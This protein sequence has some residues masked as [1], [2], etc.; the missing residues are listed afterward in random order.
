MIYVVVMK[1]GVDV[2]PYTHYCVIY[3]AVWSCIYF[4]IPYIKA[5]DARYYLFFKI[6]RNFLSQRAT[7][8]QSYYVFKMSF[9][10]FDT[11]KKQNRFQCSR[12]T[13]Y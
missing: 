9:F 1:M 5:Y 12:L 4:L 10:F 6:P 7:M 8:I 2:G 13:L 11:M 3:I